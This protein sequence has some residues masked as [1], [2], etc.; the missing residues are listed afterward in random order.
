[1]KSVLGGVIVSAMIASSTPAFGGDYNW[2][3]FYLGANAGVGINASSYKLT[4]AGAFLTDGFPATNPQRTDSADLDGPAFTG[5]V[6]GGYNWQ[7]ERFV[8]GLETDFNYNG[9][10]QTDIVNRPLARPVVGNFVHN[11]SQKLDWFGTMRG[12]AGVTPLPEWLL[13][14]TGG[15]AYG[16][17]SSETR[18]LFSVGDDLYAGSRSTTRVGWTIG[19]GSEV[20]I[21]S[22]WSIKLEYLY[23]DLG[24][25]G[26]H[27]TC[28][29][30]AALG[31]D[32][33][34]YKTDISTREH[35]V[36]IGVNYRFGGGRP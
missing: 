31:F 35:I 3:G 16:H 7:V 10:D 4:P 13:Y 29:N 14:V 6:Q 25:F 5:G 26:Y 21:A 23:V 19:A 22:A 32:P 9:V 27:D 28:V 24:T 17:V 15:L 30:C 18:V 2:T 33:L 34:A 12:R 36:R 1:M 11:V 20:A 8:V